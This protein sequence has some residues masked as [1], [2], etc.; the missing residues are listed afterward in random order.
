MAALSINALVSRL[1]P[2]YHPEL[3]AQARGTMDSA[4]WRRRFE[5]VPPQLAAG[6]AGPRCLLQRHS[7]GAEP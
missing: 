7:T 5:D 6:E 3:G 2:Q 1:I 4:R